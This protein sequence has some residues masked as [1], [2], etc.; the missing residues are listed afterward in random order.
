MDG[1]A[2]LVPFLA[3]VDFER[4]FRRAIMVAAV[5]LLWPLLRAIHVRSLDDW[6]LRPIRIGAAI[7]APESFS[8]S[9]P[10]LLR[11]C[12]ILCIYSFAASSFGRA[13]AR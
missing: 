11:C 1:G 4:F 10:A 7:F 13:F 6:A 2:R 8:R 12:L 9:S 3:G 5:L